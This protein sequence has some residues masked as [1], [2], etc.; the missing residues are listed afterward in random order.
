MQYNRRDKEQQQMRALRVRAEGQS[1]GAR[2]RRC[3]PGP[4]ALQWLGQNIALP[5]AGGAWL[6]HQKAAFTC[7]SLLPAVLTCTRTASSNSDR[8]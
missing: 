6:L 7:C 3:G 2:M 4:A 1:A 8:G 5:L